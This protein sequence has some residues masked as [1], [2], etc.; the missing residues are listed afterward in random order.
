MRLR[1]C[2]SCWRYTLRTDK[3]PYCGGE[4]VNPHPPDLMLRKEE[5]KASGGEERSE[6]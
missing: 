5:L 3:C 1:R 6:S 4:L 2:S